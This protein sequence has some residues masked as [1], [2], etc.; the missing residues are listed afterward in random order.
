M[1]CG[2]EGGQWEKVSLIRGEEREEATPRMTLGGAFQAEDTVGAKGLR[3]GVSRRPAD[4]SGVRGEGTGDG[5]REV[6]GAFFK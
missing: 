6:A 4:C 3:L 5:V 1:R 2:G